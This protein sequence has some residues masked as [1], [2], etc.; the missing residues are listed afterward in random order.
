MEVKE[1]IASRMLKVLQEKNLDQ[2]S[3]AQMLGLSQPGLNN[4]LTGKRSP[5]ADFLQKFCRIFQV[6]PNYLM[7]YDEPTTS[8]MPKDEIIDRNVVQMII[9][10]IKEWED[11]N[12]YTYSDDAK[13]DLIKLI[14][15]RVH[16]LTASEQGDE[17][18]KIID[19]YQYVKKVD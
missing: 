1:I 18:T 9:K 12:N 6:S 3:A 14:Y 5:K 4:F 19:I 16:A 15:D 10:K 2:E 7:G 8:Y 13:A 17:S 11:K